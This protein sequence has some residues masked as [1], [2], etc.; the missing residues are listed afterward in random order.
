MPGR[1]EAPGR[2]RA[3]HRAARPDARAVPGPKRGGHPTPHCANPACV[4]GAAALSRA[5]DVWQRG[6]GRWDDCQRTK[7]RGGRCRGSGR[8]VRRR[9]RLRERCPEGSGAVRWGRA[10]R[11]ACRRLA[12]ARRGAGARRR[13]LRGVA[14]RG[15]LA[16]ERT[17]SRSHTRAPGVVSSMT[18]GGSKRWFFRSRLGRCVGPGFSSTRPSSG[19][20]RGSHRAATVVWAMR[21]PVDGDM[22][23]VAR[24]SSRLG[25]WSTVR[26]RYGRAEYRV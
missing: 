8:V 24:A 7:R 14:P 4:P 1:A 11:W 5:G 2:V 21:S 22:A 18:R 17:A 25:W 13:A 10:V 23:S 26:R 6:T 9:R 15:R 3:R 16:C 19:L 12:S 20:C